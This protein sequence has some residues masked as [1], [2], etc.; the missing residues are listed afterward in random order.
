MKKWLLILAIAVTFTA[1]KWIHETFYPVDSCAEWYAEEIW[2]AVT[3]NDVDEFVE[4][5]NDCMSWME[6]LDKADR[7]KAEN[8]FEKWMEKHAS[9]ER[10]RS[11]MRSH[12]SELEG[13]LIVE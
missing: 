8:A 4:D 12:A 1:C 5:F 2:D 3:D 7:K 13:R 6:S 10:L 11:F 9:E